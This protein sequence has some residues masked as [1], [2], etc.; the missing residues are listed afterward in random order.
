LSTE[1]LTS[2]VRE[3]VLA[4]YAAFHGLGM[5][6]GDVRKE[7]ILVLEDESVRLIDF[8]NSSVASEDAIHM[9]DKEIARLLDGRQEC[10]WSRTSDD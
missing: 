7:N 1:R 8:E 3:N 9:E 5:M 2:K 10:G 4:A 6:H